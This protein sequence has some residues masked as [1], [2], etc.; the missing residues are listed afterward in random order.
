[1]NDVT[2]ESPVAY[3]ASRTL[4]NNPVTVKELRSRMRGRRAF[5]VLTIYLLL[6]SLFI[7]LVYLVYAAAA[8][9]SFGPS[10]RQAG[11]AVFGAVLAVELFLV[12]LCQCLLQ[13]LQNDES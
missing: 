2:T 7:L 11:K 8:R 6:M 10:G 9:N 1:M 3:P 12:P 5:V 4:I 13:V